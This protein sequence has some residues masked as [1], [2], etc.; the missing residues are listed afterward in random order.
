MI[1]RMPKEEVELHLEYKGKDVDDGTMSVEDLVP[2]LQGFSSAYGKIAAQV[3]PGARHR[4]RIVSVKKGSFDAVLEVWRVLGENVDPITSASI[5]TGGAVVTVGGAVRVVQ[6]IVGVIKAKRHVARKPYRERVAADNVI[7]I[8]NAEG[9]TIEIPLEVFELFKKTAIDADI[10]KM[11][12]PLQ[13]GRIESAEIRAE[14]SSGSELVKET[15]TADEKP[16]FDTSE[17]SVTS[18]KDAPLIAHLN[19]LTKT[20]NSGFLYLVDGTRVFYEYKG[21]SPAQLH[22]IFAHD[23][24]VRIQAVAH[25]DDSL[26]PVRVE[27]SHIER[28]QLDLFGAMPPPHDGG[29]DD[30]DG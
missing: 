22:Q 26:K 20:T 24:P 28:A 23:G 16:L 7:V 25:L 2:V 18:T 9:L 30:G 13:K 14:S 19:S 8:T 4:L 21:D 27:I 17:A 12:R 5:L 10:A 15:I 11:V 29:K 1:S 3:D 6:W